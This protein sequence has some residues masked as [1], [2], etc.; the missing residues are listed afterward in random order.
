[1]IASVPMLGE[2]R[3]G[4]LHKGIFNF[5]SI[6]YH[7]A[8]VSVGSALILSSLVLITV[9]VSYFL[10]SIRGTILFYFWKIGITHLFREQCVFFVLKVYFVIGTRCYAYAIFVYLTPGTIHLRISGRRDISYTFI[11]VAIHTLISNAL[12]IVLKVYFVIVI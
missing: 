5:P 3:H 7:D 6:S 12:R 2:L 9:S 1:M 8:L 10:C 11:S 4:N